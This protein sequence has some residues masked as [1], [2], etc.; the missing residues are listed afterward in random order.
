LAWWEQLNIELSKYGR[1]WKLNEYIHVYDRTWILLELKYSGLWDD[2]ISRGTKILDIFWYYMQETNRFIRK[3]TYLEENILTAYYMGIFMILLTINIRL[4]KNDICVKKCNWIQIVII[5]LILQS[6][7]CLF[8]I[9]TNLTHVVHSWKRV[10]L[11]G[12]SI[13]LTK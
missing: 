2:L 11:C 8:Q 3:F 4:Y 13:Y 12:E 7:D 9:N 6:S 5:F 10:V 1:F